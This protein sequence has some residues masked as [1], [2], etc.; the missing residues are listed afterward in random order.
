MQTCKVEE[1]PTDSKDLI[2]KCII[3]TLW[4][5]HHTANSQVAEVHVPGAH[6]KGTTAFQTG[7]HGTHIPTASAQYLYLHPHHVDGSTAA[8]QWGNPPPFS[9]VTYAHLAKG[10]GR[11]HIPKGRVWSDLLKMMFGTEPIPS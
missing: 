9:D 7:Y 11:P 2:D 3:V 4:D 10:G 5:T 6:H 1:Y 8:L